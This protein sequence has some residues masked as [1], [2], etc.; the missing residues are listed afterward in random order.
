MSFVNV[1][2]ETWHDGNVVLLGDAV[3]TAHFSIGS[4]TKLAME[5]SLA[6]ANAFV[7]HR[8]FE[9][10]FVDYEMERQ[11][12]V[13]RFQEAARDSATYFENVKH[14][15]GFDPIQFAFNLLT[16]SG[17]IGYANLMLRDPRFVRELDSWFA[18]R[19]NGGVA[20]RIA[21]PPMFAPMRVGDR[22]LGNRVVLSPPVEDG[23]RDGI[24]SERRT[25]GLVRAAGSGA[26]LC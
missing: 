21:P 17:R 11:P 25:E 15:A 8:E 3:H 4:G 22:V 12:V 24:P 26:G 9:P 18:V 19:S 1:S 14:Y 6:L 2:N 7:R 23:A 10:A 5:D 20:R 13:E 16:R